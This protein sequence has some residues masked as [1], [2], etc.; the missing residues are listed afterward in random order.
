VDT[1][2]S[3]S[4]REASWK[5]TSPRLRLPRPSLQAVGRRRVLSVHPYRTSE[6]GREHDCPLCHRPLER[7]P[8]ATCATCG[9]RWRVLGSEEEIAP[10]DL[11]S[12]EP[13]LPFRLLLRDSG[14]FSWVAVLL[15]FVSVGYGGS[16]IIW[17]L[18]HGT[19][20]LLAWAALLVSLPLGLFWGTYCLA[21][22]LQH[23]FRR[24]LPSRLEADQSTLHVR[25]WN[26]WEGLV[27]GFRRTDATVPRDQI[28]GVTF[29]TDQ[30]GNSQLF[31]AHASGLAFGTGW[32]GTREEATRLA[33]PILCWACVT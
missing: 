24:F 8:S 7:L 14:G 18:R 33:Q 31:I 25:V 11:V 23:L 15:F 13:R 32:S 19:S 20:G 4:I 27:S 5:R 10:R 17:F 30:G 28:V 22:L 6:S 29:H 1:P 3:A 26:T 12:D 9:L 16:W 2:S 21:A